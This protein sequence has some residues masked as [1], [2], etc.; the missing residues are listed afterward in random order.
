MS[1]NSWWAPPLNLGKKEL[2]GEGSYGKVYRALDRDN[3]CIV[4]VKEV[5][6]V[7]NDNLQKQVNNLEREIG[8]MKKL[9]HPNIVPYHGAKRESDIL[10]MYMEFVPGGTIG[11]L[12]RDFGPLQDWSTYTA[13]ASCTQI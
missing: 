12:L 10:S 3:N 2:I 9:S 4:A 8:V 1:L 11:S 5:V 7:P 6:L 13:S